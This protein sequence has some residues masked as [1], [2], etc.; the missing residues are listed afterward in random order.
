MSRKVD[1]K[2]RA[3]KIL[4][5]DLQK[6]DT[7]KKISEIINKPNPILIPFCT[8]IVWLPRYVPS[9]ITSLNHNI[10]EYVT[11]A[12]ATKNIMYDPS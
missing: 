10:I 11:E 12:S 3:D 1:S 2:M 5:K 9:D 8:A 7:Q 4:W 6:N